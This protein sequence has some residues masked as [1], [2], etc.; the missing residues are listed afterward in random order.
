LVWK[1]CWK[2]YATSGWESRDISG[3]F[4]GSCANPESLV[5]RVPKL[6]SDRIS[7]NRFS[8]RLSGLI[9]ARGRAAQEKN[10]AQTALWRQPGVY[11]DCQNARIEFRAYPTYLPQHAV[12]LVHSRAFSRIFDGIDGGS[13]VGPVNMLALRHG[14]IGGRRHTLACGIAHTLGKVDA[15]DTSHTR[16]A[17]R[18]SRIER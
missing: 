17:S 3:G 7:V 12:H 4:R 18:E 16:P 1:S 14:V 8:N 9:E 5:T 10:C 2:A 13:A 11:S 6:H 15:T